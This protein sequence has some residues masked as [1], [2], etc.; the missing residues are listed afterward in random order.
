MTNT[1][2]ST[3]FGLALGAMLALAVSAHAEEREEFHKT[4]PLT[5]NGS[6]AVSNINGAIKVST[7]DRN[8]VQID[9]VKTAENLEKLKEARIEV[10]GDADRV[11]VSTR[12]PEQTN[13]GAARVEYTLMV[14]RSVRIDKIENVNG[15]VEIR[16]ATSE[17]HAGTVNGDVIVDNSTGQLKL[18][19]VNGSLRAALSN[20]QK[21]AEL[22]CVNG[23][24]ELTLPSDANAHVTASTVHGSISSDFQLPVQRSRWMGSSN[25]DARLGD[26]L[27]AVKLSTVNGS[28]SVNHAADGKPLSKVTSLIAE[29]K[30]KYY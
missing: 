28:I 21:G 4:I 3:M 20:S 9:A 30:D 18:G 26:G 16:G 8:E 6:V 15:A 5:A 17:V 10:T 13:H 11:K 27:V 22:D 12:Y 25:V 14:P 23:K 7:W 1:R 19:T 29:D 24:I 2:R